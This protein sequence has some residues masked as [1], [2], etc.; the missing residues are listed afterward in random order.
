[1]MQTALASMHR[2]DPLRTPKEGHMK[3]KASSIRK[4]L[5]ARLTRRVSPLLALAPAL[6]AVGLLAPSAQAE[7]SDVMS[8][9]T[10]LQSTDPPSLD[11][12]IDA[13]PV[14]R[15]CYPTLSE[16]ISVAT[17]G[18]AIVPPDT[19]PSEITDEMVNPPTASSLD[20]TASSSTKTV[21]GIDYSASGYSGTAR[22]WSN[23][24]GC[25]ATWGVNVWYVGD[26]WNDIISSAHTYGGCDRWKHFENKNYNPYYNPG[27][28]ITCE[29][30]NN[31]CS[32]MGAMNNQTS[33]EKFRNHNWG[34]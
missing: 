33:S 15:G 27:A 4:G 20:P 5:G 16:A 11:G 31:P 2:L 10:D 30:T 21:I 1:M 22:V 18:N 3:R 9:V 25:S 6:V 17:D 7:P 34:G 12:M 8:C 24:Q 13:I 32:V 14:E 29:P 23:T 19:P 28:M 26:G